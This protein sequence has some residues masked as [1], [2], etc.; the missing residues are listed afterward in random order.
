M[1]SLGCHHSTSLYITQ[2]LQLTKFSIQSH[3]ISPNR[4]SSDIHR[5]C[6]TCWIEDKPVAKRGIVIWENFV[7]V[8][9]HW[10]GLCKLSRPPVE[11]YETL[12]NQY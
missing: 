7:K 11:S 9:S 6:P 4:N 8:I 5:F 2:H 12:F 3:L 10:E 1:D